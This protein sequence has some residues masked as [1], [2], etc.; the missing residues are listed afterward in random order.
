M[1]LRNPQQSN[2]FPWTRGGTP[3][4]PDEARA[5]EEIEEMWA[6]ADY[7]VE[8]DPAISS[9]LDGSELDVTGVKQKM[10]TARETIALDGRSRSAATSCPIVGDGDFGKELFSIR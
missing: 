8:T 7:V 6:V 10:L 2:F 9:Y 3:L 1:A 4:T 5:S